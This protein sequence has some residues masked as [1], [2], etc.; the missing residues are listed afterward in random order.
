MLI[1]NHF[2]VKSGDD[3]PKDWVD[4]MSKGQDKISLMMSNESPEQQEQQ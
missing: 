3:I 1:D 4:Y 2:A